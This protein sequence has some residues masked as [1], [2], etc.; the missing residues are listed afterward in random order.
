LAPGRSASQTIIL[1]P[2][3]W[4]LSF[5]YSSPVAPVR[6]EA[7][8]LRAEMPQGVEGAIPFRPDEGP[9]WPVGSVTSG[10]GPLEVT[11][12]ADEL[13]KVQQLLGVD[14]EAAIGNLV[15]TRLSDISSQSF[16]ASCGLYLDHYY[17]GR[18]GA[19]QISKES[20]GGPAP[21]N[22]TR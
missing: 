22:P 17:L 7:G 9:Y 15:A 14:A 16:T 21:L 5:Q 13:S 1:P 18:P 8:D 20:G 11:V 6:V 2:G 4:D 12:T 3:E 19:I 10:G